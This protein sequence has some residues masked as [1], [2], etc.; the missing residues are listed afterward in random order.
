MIVKKALSD[1]V[2]SRPHR[3]RDQNAGVQHY[4]IG[5]A[6]S[7]G[8]VSRDAPDE[9]RGSSHGAGWQ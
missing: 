5:A 6:T 8:V 3:A 2:H 7:K 4:E 9:R 1:R